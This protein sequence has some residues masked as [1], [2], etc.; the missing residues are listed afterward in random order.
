MF[1]LFQTNQQSSFFL[2]VAKQYNYK[3]GIFK[4]EMKYDL[5]RF[6]IC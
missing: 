4:K 1:Y 6:D 2:S 3:I 5:Q